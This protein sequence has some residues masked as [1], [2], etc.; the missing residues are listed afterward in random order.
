MARSGFLILVAILSLVALPAVARDGGRHGGGFHGGGF[1]GHDRFRGG[2]FFGG[3][4]GYYDPGFYYPYAVPYAQ[5]SAWYY[6]PAANAY[7][8]Y[9][10]SCPAPWQLV[11][12]Q[13]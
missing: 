3:V 11:P 1:R 7:Y 4:G 10:S 5:G 2:V 12:A 6:C 13:P 9:V 8:P